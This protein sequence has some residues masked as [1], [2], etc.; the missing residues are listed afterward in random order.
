MGE[1]GGATSYNVI[2]CFNRIVFMISQN[3]FTVCN[4]LI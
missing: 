2:G 3:V 1:R 4:G